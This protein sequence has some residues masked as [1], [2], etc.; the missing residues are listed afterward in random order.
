MLRDTDADVRT[1]GGRG[2][3]ALTGERTRLHRDL[4][5]MHREDREPAG[6]AALA[7]A[8]PLP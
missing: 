5:L 6:A 4:G 8:A 2:I 3:D 7:D 1:G